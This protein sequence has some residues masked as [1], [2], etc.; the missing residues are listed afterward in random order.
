VAA[1]CSDEDDAAPPGPTVPAGPTTTLSAAPG[2]PPE[3][4][5][6]VVEACALAA[7][8]EEA[9]EA[10]AA[11]RVEVGARIDE[12]VAAAEVLGDHTAYAWGALGSITGET[13]AAAADLHLVALLDYCAT[14]GDPGARPLPDGSS[15][16]TSTPP[17]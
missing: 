7:D 2:P 14:G 3:E 1:A 9:A 17:G 5:P 8:W 10:T 15:P 4:I 6:G 13:D 16:A 12:A 11:Q